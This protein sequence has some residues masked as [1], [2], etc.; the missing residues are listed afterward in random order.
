MNLNM[1]MKCK[2]NSWHC[3]S[4]MVSPGGKGVRSVRVFWSIFQR[5]TKRAHKQQTTNNKRQ[6]TGNSD[7]NNHWQKH[8]NSMW[9][10]WN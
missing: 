4:I 9:L 5:L 10:T 8:S 3:E 1:K 2:H 7:S 6:A